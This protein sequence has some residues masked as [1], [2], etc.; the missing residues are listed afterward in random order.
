MLWTPC[1]C[2][3]PGTE[4]ASTLI[5]D[6]QSP[7][8]GENTLPCLRPLWFAVAARADQD[9][10]QPPGGTH[11]LRLDQQ[12]TC[13]YPL[14]FSRA[15]PWDWNISLSLVKIQSTLQ[16]LS[17]YTHRKFFQTSSAQETHTHSTP[18]PRRSPLLLC[19]GPCATGLIYSAA[20]TKL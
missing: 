1:L 16:V 14:A 13:S 19:V 4:S 9:S 17:C 15:D 18:H 20:L 10:R 2:S 3:S 11:K 12:G 6:V 8:M 7:E 5:W